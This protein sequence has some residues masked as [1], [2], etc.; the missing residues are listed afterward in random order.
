MRHAQRGWGCQAGRDC[1][2]VRPA[3]VL[4]ID[5][6]TQFFPRFRFRHLAFRVT[7]SV[8]HSRIRTVWT[9]TSSECDTSGISDTRILHVVVSYSYYVLYST[10]LSRNMYA[11]KVLKR[12]GH[13]PL[14]AGRVGPPNF[15]FHLNFVQIYKLNILNCLRARPRERLRC[16]PM[17]PDRSPLPGTRRRR[18]CCC[19]RW[20]LSQQAPFS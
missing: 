17:R 12:T 10:P 14:L 9:D 1:S 19:P 15:H 8:L 11:R 18:E 5:L 7:E 2:G 4:V 3:I 20:P 16:R 13:L 6:V